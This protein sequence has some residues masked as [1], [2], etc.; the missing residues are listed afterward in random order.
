MLF[1]LI[2]KLWFFEYFNL[3]SFRNG[4]DVCH[5]IPETF[6]F[7]L[8][9]LV[10]FWDCK[11]FKRDTKSRNAKQFREQFYELITTLYKLHFLLVNKH[12][13]KRRDPGGHGGLNSSQAY[14]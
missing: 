4:L 2:H 8:Y 5:F 11:R 12:K 10:W 3:W 1:H 9:M 13:T 6:P 7:V 14:Q